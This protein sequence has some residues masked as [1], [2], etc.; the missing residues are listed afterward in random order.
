[1]LYKLKGLVILHIRLIT[2]F[3]CWVTKF[4][5]SFIILNCMLKI[6]TAIFVYVWKFLCMNDMFAVAYHDCVWYSLFLVLSDLWISL[7][8]TSSKLWGI[9]LYIS[10]RSIHS[11]WVVWSFSILNVYDSRVVLTFLLF[12]R[13]IA[14][15]LFFLNLM[16]R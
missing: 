8:Y 5:D 2:Q 13:A 3:N 1:M 6:V 9:G 14:L 4:V 12:L 16:W 11:F 15:E 10:F 7:V